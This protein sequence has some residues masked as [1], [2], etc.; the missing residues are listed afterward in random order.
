MAETI[1][2]FAALL[3]PL[4]VVAALLV[5]GKP[6]MA[7]VRSAEH[8]EWTL[9]VGGQKLNMMQLSDQQNR[10]IAD[11]QTQ[12]SALH[13]RIA[14]LDPGAV[15]VQTSE[16]DVI[17]GQQVARG[18]DVDSIPPAVL[19]VDDHP[20]NNALIAEQLQRNGVRV[21][22]A[23]STAEGLAKL[24][25]RR[26]G[27]VL[28]DMG[29]AED[30]APVSD[31]GVRLLKAVRETHP[32]IPYLI[33]CGPQAATTYREAA[34]AAGADVITASPGVLTDRLHSLGLL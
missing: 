2:S 14:E 15:D 10:S 31:A 3:W 20:S 9:E 30:G 19:W 22:V 33:Y 21:D 24:G 12:I 13:Q 1:T 6:L 11:L 18:R 17:W 7:V 34:T 26:Y 25:T 27:A 16:P 8:R 4:L 29:R 28:S 32:A 23:L 5:F